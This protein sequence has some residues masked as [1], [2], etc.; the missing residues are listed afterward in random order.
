MFEAL[1]LAPVVA[2]AL[3]LAPAAGCVPPCTGMFELEPCGAEANGGCNMRAPAF[4]PAICGSTICGTAWA[5]EGVRDTDWYAIVLEAPT[6]VTLT[7][8]T[9]LPMVVG[10]VDTN[11][12]ATVG[13]VTPFAD[14]PLCGTATVSHCVPAGVWWIFVAPG[15]FDG[16]PCGT[17]NDYRLAIECG[18]ACG[19]VICG[20]GICNGDESAASCPQDC[21]LAVACGGGGPCDAPHDG[22]G[23]DDLLCC[24]RVCIADPFCCQ[25]QWDALCAKE[26]F[27]LC[28][29]PAECDGLCLGDIT[30]DGLVAG[31][32]IAVVL[33][34]WQTNDPCADLDG[35]GLV[36]GA[37][38]ALVLGNWGGCPAFA[39]PAS[40]GFGQARVGESN[41][42]AINIR[43]PAPIDTAVIAIASSSPEFIVQPPLPGL[44]AGGASEPLIVEFKPGGTGERHEFI[45]I[46]LQ[47]GQ[48]I[49][50]PVHGEGI[51]DQ[52]SPIDQWLDLE[53][54]LVSISVDDDLQVVYHY[55]L[56]VAPRGPVSLS[57]DAASIHFKVQD[58][59]PGA[60]AIVPLES[61]AFG[62]FQYVP[63][64]VIPPFGGFGTGLRFNIVV[65]V[66]NARGAVIDIRFINVPLV[67][68]PP[69]A[70]PCPCTPPATPIEL[71]SATSYFPDS[72]L[73]LLF[74]PP[75]PPDPQI[76]PTYDPLPGASVNKVA[77]VRTWIEGPKPGTCCKG[78]GSLF[79]IR[80][81]ISSAFEWPLTDPPSG[82]DYSVTANKWHTG[83]ALIRACR[84]VEGMSI[85]AKTCGL[86]HGFASVGGGRSAF[87]CPGNDEL[88]PWGSKI[89][90]IE[91]TTTWETPIKCSNQ[92]PW[93]CTMKARDFVTEVSFNGDAGTPAQVP[94]AG[95]IQVHWGVDFASNQC[96]LM[97]VTASI[98]QT[99]FM[100]GDDVYSPNRHGAGW[101]H[102]SGDPDGD[103]RNNHREL[104][105]GTDPLSAD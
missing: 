70:P 37:D 102:K 72:P 98:K 15:G 20:D 49:E 21:D 69:P 44:L 60:E 7:L 6:T 32:D 91:L 16:F 18:A 50:V 10:F 25:V 103:G 45:S 71:A 2:S 42:D 47:N 58:L 90:K 64:A 35:S 36:G 78:P 12:C 79:R 75:P 100:R 65:E 13:G 61:I 83:H 9:S 94:G 51:P 93:P 101:L 95:G 77:M 62:E 76:D 19:Q 89:G 33:G 66:R 11:D 96:L 104:V 8:E 5:S 55:A 31:A 53:P 28:A 23:C 52:D 68:T 14:A 34:A 73:D 97:P 67:I 86:D 40:M 39:G 48:V 85:Q 46:L 30:G 56:R 27:Q 22:I 88:P 41:V 105:D 99:I 54:S 80:L 24:S 92:T 59:P 43:N 87:A 3:G 17:T 38:L 84:G 26:G 81:N 63:V 82:P 1:V 57:H 74:N 29:G 4:E